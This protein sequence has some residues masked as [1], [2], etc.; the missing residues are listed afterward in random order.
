MVGLDVPLNNGEQELAVVDQPIGANPS[1]VYELHQLNVVASNTPGVTENVTYQKTY[2]LG[3]VEVPQLS[4][5]LP[6]R[7]VVGNV[8]VNDN[9]SDTAAKKQAISSGSSASKGEEK[10]GKVVKQKKRELRKHKSKDESVVDGAAKKPVTELVIPAQISLF[11]DWNE[12]VVMNSE[13]TVTTKKAGDVS[14]ILVCS[15]TSN[16][17]SSEA[18]VGWIAMSSSSLH[19][20]SLEA[21]EIV[22]DEAVDEA[23]PTFNEEINETAEP[24]VTSSGDEKIVA[25]NDE[26]PATNPSD[27]ADDEE[28][29][30]LYQGRSTTQLCKTAKRNVPSNDDIEVIVLDDEPTGTNPSV[31][32]TAR[33]N[34]PFRVDN[35]VIVVNDEPNGTNSSEVYELHQLNVVVSNTPSATENVIYQKTYGVGFVKD[36]QLSHSIQRPRLYGDAP[37]NENSSGTAAKEVHG[38]PQR[39]VVSN[40]PSVTKNVTYQ[41]TYGLGHRKAPQSSRSLQRLPVDGNVLVNENSSG[42]AAKGVSGNVAAD[43]VF[44]NILGLL[45]IGDEVHGLQQRYV[46]SNRPSVAK[47]ANQ[48]TYG[49]GH[50]K[51]PL[52]SRSLQ[53]LPV[54]GNVLV[55]EKSSGTTAKGVYEVPK[56]NV[57]S[58]TP[59]AKENLI[60]QKTYGLGL[61]EVRIFL[62]ILVLHSFH[63]LFYRNKEPA[64]HSRPL[65]YLALFNVF[66]WLEF[67]L[68]IYLFIYFY[69]HIRHTSENIRTNTRRT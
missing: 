4:Y 64:I 69:V 23:A 47:N 15:E 57:L 62:H 9:S 67:Y 2:G 44:S 25:G 8:L 28:V 46:V 65:S 20:R 1:Q 12:N 11:S 19:F 40:R 53:R 29:V 42:T 16:R 10:E 59:I 60:Y 26:F 17:I 49:L 54:D 31:Y 50:G 5:S 3:L 51:A 18:Q 43:E 66:Q 33:L 52:L 13:A 27:P 45:A 61:V 24:V 22:G 39:Y 14:E 63:S 34:V 35:E 21:E 7:Q 36:L 55:N 68:F 41:K 6:R 38:L 58:N 32:E 30:V 48:K 56:L 37:V